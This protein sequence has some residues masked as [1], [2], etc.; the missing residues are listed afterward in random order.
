MADRDRDQVARFEALR[1]RWYP[2][3]NAVEVK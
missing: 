3:T 2:E 1:N